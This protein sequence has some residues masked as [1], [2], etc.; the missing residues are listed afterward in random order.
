MK[1]NEGENCFK[2][3][4]SLQSMTIIFNYM[5]TRIR[6][7]LFKQVLHS[8]QLKGWQKPCHQNQVKIQT[9]P[10]LPNGNK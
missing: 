8:L 5:A 7:L 3:P 9:K 2:P 1:S 4:S 10:R 6:L